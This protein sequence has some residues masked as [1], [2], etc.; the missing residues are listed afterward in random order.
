MEPV[1]TPPAHPDSTHDV[2]NQAPPLQPYNVYEADTALQEALE[3]EGGGWGADSLRRHRRAGR[4][5]RGPRALRALRAQ[6]ARAQDA[7]PLRQPG[8]RD[9]A[10][11]VLALAAARGHRARHPL[12]ALGRPATRRPHGARRPDVPVGPGQRGRDVS[13]LDDPLGH[14]RPARGARPGRRVGAASDLHRVRPRQGRHRGHGHDREAG[15]LGRARQH[16]QRGRAERR[17]LRDHRPQ[18]VLLLPAVR[19]VPDAGPGAGRAFRA[20]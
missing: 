2:R 20:S 19:R 15:R 9:P 18:V 8:G 12:A 10:G 16:H 7:R 17:H 6:R 13:H 14:P 1:S 3:R 11:P 5:A 4:L